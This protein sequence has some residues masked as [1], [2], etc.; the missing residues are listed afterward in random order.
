MDVA[1]AGAVE[2]SYNGTDFVQINELTLNRV[3]TFT[4]FETTSLKFDGTGEIDLGTIT[5]TNAA[6][7]LKLVDL[8]GMS[9][10]FHMGAGG[11][12]TSA[13]ALTSWSVA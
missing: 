9:G 10:V 12:Q 3:E 11:T 1:Q 7:G 2:I 4:T 13:P 8:T 5:D 6:T